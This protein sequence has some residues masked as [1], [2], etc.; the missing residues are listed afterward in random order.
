MPILHSRVD[1][2]TSSSRC[3]SAKSAGG[4]RADHSARCVRSDLVPITPAIAEPSTGETMGQSAEKMAKIN[5]IPREEQ[6]Q[7][8][9]RS[10]R[11]AAVGH[12][13]TD[14]S[15]PR[16]CRSTCRRRYETSLT[17]DNGIRADTSIEQLRALKPV[18]DRKYGTVTAGNSSPLTD[19]AS[20]V[21]LMS[22]ERAKALGYTPLAFIRSYAYAALDPGEQ[23]LM[24]PVLAAPV[25]LQRAGLTLDDM[26][27]IEMHE[28]FAAQVLCNLE[29]LRVARMGGARRLRRSRSAKSTARSST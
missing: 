27:L 20:A 16:S 15:R 12:A 4:A 14:G 22:E 29:G 18:F 24:G 26:D 8:A 13:R 6:D 3:R 5:H 25:A 2:A 11:L 1:V 28:A 19:G 9:L 7:F 10:H 17:S 21:L 23:L